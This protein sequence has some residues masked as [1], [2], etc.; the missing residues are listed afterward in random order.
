[1]VQVTERAATKARE[2]L[3]QMGAQGAAVRVLVNLKGCNCS[4]YRMAIDP[5]V[6]PE[7]RVVE[8]GGVRFVADPEAARHLLGAVIDFL[9]EN[10]TGGFVIRGPEQAGQGGCGCGAH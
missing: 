6:T 10:G 1:M 3:E 5:R 7:D 4:R 8:V 9:E 2:V